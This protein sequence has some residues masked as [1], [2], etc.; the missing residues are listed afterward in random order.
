M[1]ILPPKSELIRRL[2][3]MDSI[4]CN[5]CNGTGEVQGEVCNEYCSICDGVGL[6]GLIKLDDHEKMIC[7]KQA[8][9]TEV[10]ILAMYSDGIK[11]LQNR[12]KE[13]ERELEKAYN[14]SF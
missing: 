1:Q 3:L 7:L 9:F 14:G 6:K 10:E 12:I 2:D 11:K 13:L 8:G 4:V 5:N